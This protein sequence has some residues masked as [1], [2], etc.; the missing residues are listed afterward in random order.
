LNIQKSSFWTLLP[1]QTKKTHYHIAKHIFSKI[2][3]SKPGKDGEDAARGGEHG[4]DSPD[5][6]PEGK[7]AA[8]G[9][10]HGV[11]HLTRD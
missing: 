3:M 10:E 2:K 5:D 6:G 11:A 4:V 8:G 1:T 9:G 7:D